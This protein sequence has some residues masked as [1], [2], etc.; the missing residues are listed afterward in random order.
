MG[1]TVLCGNNGTGK[2]TLAAL[3]LWLHVEP[4]SSSGLYVAALGFRDAFLDAQTAGTLEATAQRF[5][6]P[7]AMV[8]DDVQNVPA[9]DA[10]L[11]R[12]RDVI[13]ARYRGK[14]HTLIV[15]NQTAD[16]VLKHLGPQIGQRIGET[17]RIVTSGWN[18]VRRN[19]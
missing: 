8:I 16:T 9:S 13:D 6:R 7:T 5:S 4:E 14:R 12:L 19:A 10:T 17:G 3:W 15:T 11:T 2:T 18:P 1:V